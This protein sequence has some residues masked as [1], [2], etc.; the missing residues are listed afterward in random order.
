[1]ARHDSRRRLNKNSRSGFKGVNEHRP[2]YW[3]ARCKQRHI[4]YYRTPQEAALAYDVAA[5]L[6]WG[7]HA[8]TNDKL[9]LL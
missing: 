8:M 7:R 6:T 5:R 1:M 3:R 4:G 9:G 2:G